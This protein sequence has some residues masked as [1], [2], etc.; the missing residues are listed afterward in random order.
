VWRSWFKRLSELQ[1]FS[2]KL[3]PVADASDAMQLI[4]A[5]I[6]QVL[7]SLAFI[8]PTLTVGACIAKQLL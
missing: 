2:A 7:Q 4:N 5:N 6:D 8:L 3:L 1:Q